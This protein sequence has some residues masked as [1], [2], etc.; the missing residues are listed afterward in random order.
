LTKH[1]KHEEIKENTDKT[2][3]TNQP[4]TDDTAKLTNQLKAD[5]RNAFFARTEE[6][7]NMMIIEDME[8]FA[9]DVYEFAGQHNLTFLKHY[10]GQLTTYIA[11]FDFDKISTCI[12]DIK[13]CFK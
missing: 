8:N 12:S 9:A 13:K 2:F 3:V 4:E 11:E 7:E 5:F 10:A 1:L 6:L